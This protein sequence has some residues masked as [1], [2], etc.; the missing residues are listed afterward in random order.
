MKKI[1]FLLFIISACFLSSCM[2]N[3]K[4]EMF[5]S[6]QREWCEPEIGTVAKSFIGDSIISEGIERATDS[7]KLKSDYGSLAWGTYTP[8]GDYRYCGIIEVNGEPTGKTDGNNQPIYE[9]IK[10]KKYRYPTAFS[11]GLINYY[12][13]LYKK[14][15]GDVYIKLL[16]KKL[17]NSEYTETK[18]YEEIGNYF[19]Q[20]L[21][22]TGSDGNF[23]KFSYREFQNDLARAAFTIDAT[24]D[25]SK[26][27]VLRFKNCSLEVIKVDNQSITY[28]LLSGFKTEK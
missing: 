2:S 1:I 27:K 26:D 4:P 22:Y 11:D 8:A 6:E 25:I 3:E 20:K 15:N 23:L 12:P 18:I 5:L 7:I 10:A 17:S 24:Y 28:K 19:E 14:D 9:K 13:S 16:K 21:I